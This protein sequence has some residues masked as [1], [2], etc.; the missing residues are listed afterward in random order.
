MNVLLV[1]PDYK[2]K[3]PPLGLMKI[4]TLHKSRGDVIKFVKGCD[5]TIEINQFNRIYISTLFTFYWAKTIKTI[6][7]YNRHKSE[8]TPLYVGGVL[9]TLF[10]DELAQQFK[11]IKIINGLIT[12]TQQLDLKPRIDFSKLVPDYEILETIDYHY[13][14]SDA[15]MAYTTRGCVNRCGFCAVPKI[16]PIFKNYVSLFS[17][18]P[19][20]VQKKDLVLLDNNI[21]ASSQF[22]KIVSDIRKMG[23]TQNAKLGQKLRRVDFNQG[24]DA[25]LF[26]SKKA[27]L[28]AKLP[29]KVLRFSFDNVNL[30]DQY[31]RAIKLAVKAKFTKLCTYILYNYRDTPETLYKRLLINV[32]LGNKL[33]VEIASFPMRY[34]PLNA[35]NRKYTDNN[36]NLKFLRGVS[37]ILLATHGIV[38]GYEPFFKAAFGKDIAEFKQILSMPEIYIIYRKP[39]LKESKAWLKLYQELSIAQKKILYKTCDNPISAGVISQEKDPLL[40]KIYKHYLKIKN[41]RKH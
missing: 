22:S 38:G 36:W 40:R 27:A 39:Y 2:N 1:E 23:F 11:K 41:P 3:Y 7:F 31:V 19:K 37:S 34:I 25:R 9:A 17:Q 29:M 20:D 14:L 5:R 18:I 35:K 8:R 32:S 6:K 28:L 30:E 24:L 33:G 21:L 26:D 12:N 13:P 15:Y 4:S 16:E 10:E